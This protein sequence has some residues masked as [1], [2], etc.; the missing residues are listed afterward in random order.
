MAALLLLVVAIQSI[1]ANGFIFGSKETCYNNDNIGCFSNAR[2][3]NNAHGKLPES[4]EHMQVEFLL[5]TRANRN[6]P[7]IVTKDAAS[8]HGS[9]FSGTK[10][11]KFIV[12]GYQ[13]D[14]RGPWLKKMAGAFLT[15][16]DMNVFAVNWAK[17]AD[18][19]NYAQAAANTRVVGALIAQFITSLHTN[20][21]ASYETF[22]LIGH[23]LGSHISG[24]AGERIHKIGHITGLDPAGPLFEKQDIRVRL[25]PSDAMFVDAI[26]TDGDSLL[27]LGFGLE[28][29]I[30][31]ADFYPNGGE[32]QP[33]CVHEV[34][35]HLF[36]LIT[37]KIEGFTDRVACSHMRVLDL[38]IESINSHCHFRS[39]PCANKNDFN[40]GKC[41]SCGH[42]CADMGVTAPRGHPHGTFYL[43][44]NAASPFCQ[45]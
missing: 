25:D 2:P 13:D 37:G 14:G 30:A 8:I 1:F 39:Y 41:T 28:K 16:G 38:Y 33:G 20:T 21:H 31:H 6:T 42:G 29:P 24:Y 44:T 17:G 27:E 32:K 45:H 43:T 19:I 18:N 35:K 9:H 7:Q 26:H 36:S 34:G 22:H 4:P 40:G 11:T 10:N 12:H 15:K 23:S 3:Y 5:Y